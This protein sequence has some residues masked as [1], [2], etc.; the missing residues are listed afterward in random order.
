MGYL[1][2]HFKTQL[3]HFSGPRTL[4]HHMATFANELR[5]HPDRWKRHQYD[6][7]WHDDPPALVLYRGHQEDAMRADWE[8]LVAGIDGNVDESS[9]RMGAGYAIGDGH[10]PIRAFSAPVG[11]PSIHS[12]RSC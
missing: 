11:G 6:F 8:G 5:Q 7:H 1:P 2:R 12:A 9:E 3:W 4:E 10:I